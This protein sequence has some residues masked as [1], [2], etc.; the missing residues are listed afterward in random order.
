MR[1][2]TRNFMLGKVGVGS[3]HPVSIQSMCNTLTSDADA[4]LEQLHRLANAGCQISRVSVDKDEDIAAL[5]R[6]NAESPLPLV[7]DIQFN[8]EMAVKAVDAGCAAIRLN[9]GIVRDEDMLKV[10]ARK[11]ISSNIPIRVGANAGSLPRQDIECRLNRGIPR[12]DAIAEGLCDAAYLQCQKLEQYGVRNIKV[13][14]KCSDVRVT[15]NACRR[16]AAMTDY[17][18]HLGLTEAGTPQR[19][20]IKSAAA[21]GALLP[22]GI[23]D[24]IRI[25]LTASP[26]EEIHAAVRILEACGIR[27]AMPEIV[28]CPSC[29]RTEIDLFGLIND[30]ETVVQEFKASGR[31]TNLKKIAVMGCPVNGPGE[32]RDAD[33]GISGTRSGELIIFRNGEVIR[34][35]TREEALK[36]FISELEK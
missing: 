1:R 28:S 21:L 26:E 16:F 19:G 20:I 17:P 5:Y 27:D 32:A 10:V 8:A 24:T 15:V 22:D 30:I 23:G 3:D 25:S 11:V 12:E 34:Q 13:A 6:I 18:L 29:G 35:A 14:L 9:P 33:L 2:K 7:A 31:Q 36:F 4:T